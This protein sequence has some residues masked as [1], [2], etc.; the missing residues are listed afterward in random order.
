MRSLLFVLQLKSSESR[1]QEL[2]AQLSQ[3]HKHSADTKQLLQ[4]AVPAGECKPQDPQ[5]DPGCTGRD[6]T[7]CMSPCYWEYA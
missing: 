7:A 3:S 6:E 1:V 4:V 5:N 2:E